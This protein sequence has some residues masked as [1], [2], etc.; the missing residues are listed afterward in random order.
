MDYKFEKLDWGGTIIFNVLS[1]LSI[2]E[3]IGSWNWTPQKAQEIISGVENGRTKPK[4]EAY[5]WANE[6]VYVISN[7]NG[8]FLIDLMAHRAGE[9]DSEKLGLQL[10]HDEFLQFMKDFKAFIEENS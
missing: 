8:L 9:T 4:E 3:N 7:E 6:D 5:E 10:T 2:I 1:D